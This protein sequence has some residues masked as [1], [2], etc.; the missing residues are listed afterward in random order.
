MERSKS[1]C[2]VTTGDIK[3]VATA[4]RALGLA[5]HLF[6]LGWKVSILMEDTEENRTRISLECND[7][8]HVYFFKKASVVN[9][10]KEKNKLI[11]QIS[12]DILYIC[13]FVTRNIVG[14]CFHGKKLV[15]HSELMSEIKGMNPLKKQYYKLI[16][17]IS[18]IYSDGLLN[19]SK[20]LQQYYYVTAAKL[21]S[22][23][24][25]ML[26]FP[27]AYNAAVCKIADPS[28]LFIKKDVGGKY[29]VYIGNLTKNYGAFTMLK[30]FETIY[31]EYPKYHLMLL[32][33]GRDYQKVIDYITEKDLKS[34]IHAQG[35]VEEKDI[36]NYFT[37]ADAFI[38][39]MN[40]TIQDWARC[41]SKLYMYLPYLKPIITCK[42]GEP[43]EVLK[44]KGIYYEPSSVESL[45]NAL[46]DLSK[47]S[48][49][50]LEIDPFQHEWKQ[51][52]IEFDSWI[53]KTYFQDR[54]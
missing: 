20:F 51:R 6:E 49:W 14:L 23:N 26:Y 16:E 17:Y 9:E 50:T 34:Y 13:A 4:K 19:A 22:K 21:F 42:I 54:N 47:K 7:K 36:S 45:T 33:K 18:V 31:K 29:F 38:S 46:K 39:P 2:F 44:D 30:A 10:I 53:K 24:K 48:S 52:A 1:I 12:P 43:Y 37:L 32:G 28:N 11:R 5:N 35:Y 15:E 8:I 3:Y 27:Y 41:P 40:D 25:P